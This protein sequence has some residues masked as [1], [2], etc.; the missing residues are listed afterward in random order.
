M[1]SFIDQVAEEHDFPVQV[2]NDLTQ[3]AKWAV[4]LE[5]ARG[6]LSEEFEP[7]ELTA[8]N[9]GAVACLFNVA[10]ELAQLEV[11][12]NRLFPDEPEEYE[13][14]YTILEAVSELLEADG[15]ELDQLPDIA[16]DDHSEWQLMVECLAD[17]VLW[18]DDFELGDVLVDEDPDD[19]HARKEMFGIDQ[20]YF[21]A[22]APDPS[23]QEVKKIIAE[24]RDYCVPY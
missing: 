20:N 19:A 10:A 17:A 8:I 6:L 12:G 18:D 16:C 14:R 4:M 1:S 22:I 23:D 7:V 5:V 21:T 3:Q 15:A 9:E 11:D 2:F 13:V 24:L